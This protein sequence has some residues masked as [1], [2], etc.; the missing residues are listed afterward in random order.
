MTGILKG[1]LLFITAAVLLSGCAAGTAQGNDIG[2]ESGNVQETDATDFNIDDWLLFEIS[3]WNF[4][5]VRNNIYVNGTNLP[6]P[7]GLSELPKEF[8]TDNENLYFNSNLIGTVEV[9]NNEIVTYIFN[10]DDCQKYNII[11]DRIKP[12][13]TMDSIS[14]VYGESNDGW[15]VNN[16]ITTM[17]IYRFYDGALSIGNFDDTSTYD[18]IA[19]S[20]RI[21]E[22]ENK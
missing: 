3:D 13:D 19:V 16:N 4:S 22:E 17:M 8:S 14:S 10:S 11:V 15:S 1:A 18:S 9:Q 6:L 2:A 5:D 21:Y 12:N 7:C 20:Y